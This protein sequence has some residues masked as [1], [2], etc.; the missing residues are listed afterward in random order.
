MEILA[1]AMCRRPRFNITK[2][3]WSGREISGGRDAASVKFCVVPTQRTHATSRLT[4]K[5]MLARKVALRE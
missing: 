5:Q 3:W 1:A 2:S 4:N